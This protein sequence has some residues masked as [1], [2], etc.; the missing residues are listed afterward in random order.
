MVTSINGSHVRLG[1]EL[2]DDVKLVREE[3]FEVNE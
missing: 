2:P 1:F 3:I